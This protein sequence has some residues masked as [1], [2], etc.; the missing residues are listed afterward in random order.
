MVRGRAREYDRPPERWLQQKAFCSKK[1]VRLETLLQQKCA[2]PGQAYSSITCDE[3]RMD[4]DNGKERNTEP[5]FYHKGQNI[6]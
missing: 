2:L 1:T 5:K 3:D 6:L 4:Q